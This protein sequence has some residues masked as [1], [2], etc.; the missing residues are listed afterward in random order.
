MKKWFLLVG[1]LFA[2]VIGGSC[3]KKNP[4]MRLKYGTFSMAGSDS[5]IVLYEDRSLSVVNYDLSELEKSTYEDFLIAQVNLG[6]EDGNK[7]SV[8]EEQKIRDDIDL[9]RQFLDRVNPFEEVL[10]EGC[11]GIYVPVENCDLFFYMQFYPSDNS[12]VFDEH[13][14][15]FEEG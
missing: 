7:L 10:E 11:I 4:E 14:F 3:A 15:S 13:I 5:R 12:I 9:N 8:D 1:V 2:V 6:R